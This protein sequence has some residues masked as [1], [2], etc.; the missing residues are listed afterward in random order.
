[1]AIWNPW[2]GCKK[3]SPGCANCYVYRR[4]SQFDRDASQVAKTASFS[5]PTKKNRAGQY[6]L[7]AQDNPIYTCMTSD[8]FLEEARL[9][10][11]SGLGDDSPT[12]GFGICHYH[13]AHPSL[14]RRTS[15]GLGGGVSQCHH[16]LHL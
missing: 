16:C 12:P 15:L 9:L 3:Y 5:L 4:D 1:M 13:Q 2:H 8:F 11:P 14:F 7:T 10:A 6:R